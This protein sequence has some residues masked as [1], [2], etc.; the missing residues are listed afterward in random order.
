MNPGQRPTLNPI[1]PKIVAWVAAEHLRET[2]STP[3]SVEF[4]TFY[5][6]EHT[7]G[8]QT[9]QKNARI[10]TALWPISMPSKSLKASKKLLR[11]VSPQLAVLVTKRS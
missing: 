1:P 8:L 9:A 10:D 2:A 3:F 6:L 5:G 4:R 11:F 7:H